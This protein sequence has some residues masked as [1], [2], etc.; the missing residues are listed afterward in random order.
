MVNT[1][2]KSVLV[3]NTTWLQDMLLKA[4]SETMATWPKTTQCTNTRRKLTSIIYHCEILKFVWVNKKHSFCR[5]AFGEAAAI[6]L[7]H[8]SHWVP[9]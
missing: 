8:K 1:D 7:F 9:R 6:I 3:F 4:A 2:A 5:A